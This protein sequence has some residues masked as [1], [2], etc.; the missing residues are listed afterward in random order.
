A[1]VLDASDPEPDGHVAAVPQ[2]VGLGHFRSGHLL[3]GLADVL[4]HGF[5]PG[6]G[7]NPGPRHLDHSTIHVRYL[8]SGLAWV[9]TSVAPLREGV[10]DPRRA[11]RAPRALRAL[12]R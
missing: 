10:P 9:L 4:V 7:V 3:H 8:R 1:A 5:D 2:S 12:S 6:P 11:L